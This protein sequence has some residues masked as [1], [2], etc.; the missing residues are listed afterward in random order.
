MTLFYGKNSVTHSDASSSSVSSQAVNSASLTTPI[1]SSSLTPSS[2]LHSETST[3][4]SRKVIAGILSGTL[5]LVCI[6]GMTLLRRRTRLL[7]SASQSRPDP[8]PSPRTQNSF[9][10]IEIRLL[11]GIQRR[12]RE[13]VRAENP[14]TAEHRAMQEISPGYDEIDPPP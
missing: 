11:R 8:L 13:V 9:S 6:A 2:I 10:H 4:K 5:F 3:N 1:L 7:N 14:K 12:V